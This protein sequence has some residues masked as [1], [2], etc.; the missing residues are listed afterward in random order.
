MSPAGN[1]MPVSAESAPALSVPAAEVRAQHDRVLASSS[2][3]H[4]PQLQRLLRFLV[5]ETLAGHGDRLKEYVIGVEV[6]GRPAS[7]DPRL[8][9]LVR[10]EVRRLRAALAAYYA[11]EGRRDPIVIDIGKGGYQPAFRRRTPD[12]LPPARRRVFWVLLG[13]VVVALAVA[14]ITMYRRRPAASPP[15]S[16]A[17][18]PFDNLSSDRENGY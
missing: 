16:V 5:S 8:D 12:E 15:R 6:F 13:I 2:L 11:E 14:A 10:V 9:S 7:Y 3:Q 4:S 17:V 1:S 18:L